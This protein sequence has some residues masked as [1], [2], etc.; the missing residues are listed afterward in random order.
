MKKLSILEYILIGAMIVS[1]VISGYLV[2]IRVLYGVQHICYDA[3]IFGTN[4][5]LLLQIY[6]NHHAT[7]ATVAK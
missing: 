7:V 3:W 6:D 1:I 4:I 5:A 2:L